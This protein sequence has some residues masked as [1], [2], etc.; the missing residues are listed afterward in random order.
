MLS[1][2]SVRNLAGWM[3]AAT[4]RAIGAIDRANENATER[5]CT[6]GL[7]FHNPPRDLFVG[8]VNW[9]RDHDYRFLSVNDLESCFDNGTPL[10]KGSAWISFDDAWKR[11]LTEVIPF[12]RACNLPITV[13]VPT[14]EARRGNF[15]FSHALKNANALPEPFRRNVSQL[16]HVPESTRQRVL[17]DLFKAI[18]PH[19]RE[20]MS[21]E[22]IAE[23]ATVPQVTIGSHSVN[24]ALMPNCD[25]EQLRKEIN[26][27]KRELEQWAGRPVRVFSYPNG[28]FD[29]R[30]A[31]VLAEAGYTLAFTTENRAIT[32][33][34]DRYYLP[35]L[36]IMDDGSLTENICHAFGLWSPIVNAVKAM[37]PHQK[38]RAKELNK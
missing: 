16:W 18:T 17:A 37:K 19:A 2:R 3:T 21:A 4:I 10:P 33:S 8:V 1:G 25:D 15:W 20:V 11:N 13:F 5:N 24:H 23:L 38:I 34:D 28:D 31:R 35:R 22:E 36:S 7:Y 26:D 9:F 29:S 12:V 27:S 32:L 30:T 14:E 6:L